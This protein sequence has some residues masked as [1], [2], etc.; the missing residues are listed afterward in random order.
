[1]GQ[2]NSGMG[3]E[4]GMVS[5][6]QGFS[7]ATLRFIP[8]GWGKYL[9]SKT[10]LLTFRCTRAMGKFGKTW[11][12]SVGGGPKKNSP[13]AKRSRSNGKAW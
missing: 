10:S 12:A 6:T 4:S 5:R 3:R 8:G 13:L 9:L 2:D 7:D 1:M 11:S